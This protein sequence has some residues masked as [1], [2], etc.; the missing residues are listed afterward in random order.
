MTVRIN[1]QFQWLCSISVATKLNKHN[2]GGY[3]FI[4]STYPSA[5][6]KR[7]NRSH[8]SLEFTR[9][10]RLC[11][12]A[13]Q[14]LLVSLSVY[15]AWTCKTIHSLT[16]CDCYLP[17]NMSCTRPHRVW[18]TGPL[19]RSCAS[20]M[21]HGHTGPETHITYGTRA[22]W[23]NHSSLLEVNSIWEY[24]YLLKKMSQQIFYDTCKKVVKFR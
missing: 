19:V 3:L 2:N 17:L 11:F 7:T 20:Q 21:T 9:N 13:L 8:N 6:Q 23:S 24:C 15:P 1:W 4:V 22:H 12:P 5:I 10:K 16:K 14:I 18:H